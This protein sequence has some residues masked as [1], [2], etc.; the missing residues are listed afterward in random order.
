[1]SE[2][3]QKR[4]WFQYHLSTAIILM[5]VASG[6]LWLNMRLNFAIFRELGPQLD[7][8]GRKRIGLEVGASLGWPLKFCYYGN[9]MFVSEG[10]VREEAAEQCRE[11]LY[12]M[13][14]NSDFSQ[15][16][17]LNN[18]ATALGILVVV[19]STCEYF[20]RRRDLKR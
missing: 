11:Q 20:I 10:H 16:A 3:P 4:P 7:G 12:D 9:G 13:M 6:L 18:I 15:E 1:M 19:A 5:F 8:Q 17:M 14:K 2:Q